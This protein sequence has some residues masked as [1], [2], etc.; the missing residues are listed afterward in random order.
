MDENIHLVQQLQNG[1]EN[2]FRQLVVS[3]QDMVVRTAY[4][5]LKDAKEAEDLAQEVFISVYQNISEFR[6][7]A[8]L[9]TWIYRIT[10]NKSLNQIRKLK[11]KSAFQS[12]ENIVFPAIQVKDS[13]DPYIK[14]I[15][16][17]Q[18][19][20]LNSAMQKLPESQRT[21]FVLHKYDDLS[22]LEIA[23]IMKISVAAVESLIHRAKMNLQ[24]SLIEIKK[25]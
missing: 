12:I 23:E 1:D 17:E 6:N 5:Y 8:N 7:E 18:E 2:A 25:S 9:K 22:Q 16:K 20:I 19:I 21:A 3:Y 24:K 4:A 11:W 10:I 13:S 15:N 14:L